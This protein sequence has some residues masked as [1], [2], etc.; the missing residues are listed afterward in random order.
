MNAKDFTLGIVIEER[1]NTLFLVQLSD[2]REILAYISGK[3]RINKIRL[4]V[5]DEVEVLLDPYKGKATNRIVR[6]VDK[7]KT[8]PQDETIP[9]PTE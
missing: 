6:R 1:P 9:A 8:R 5:G 3:M 4:M 7:K 2:N